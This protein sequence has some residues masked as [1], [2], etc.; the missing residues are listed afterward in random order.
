MAVAE[1][2]L[3]VGALERD[4]VAHAEDLQLGGV[5]SVT[6]V[7]RLAT[8]VRDSPCSERL[9]RSSLG[10][11]VTTM[12]PSSL[13]DT[14]IGSAMSRV[15]VPWALDRHVLALDGHVDSGGNRNRLFSN[16]RHVL[17]PPYQT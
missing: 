1:R 17:F 4:A 12:A 13:R 8:S 16:T 5:A 2:E 15:R 7:T 9:R 6:P 11:R 10:G 3:Q 14:T